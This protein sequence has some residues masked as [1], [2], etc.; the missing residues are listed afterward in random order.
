MLATEGNFTWDGFDAVNVPCPIGI[1][2]IYIEMFSL[3]GEKIVEKHA[4]VLSRKSY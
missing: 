4:A 2:I 3:N 1:Y